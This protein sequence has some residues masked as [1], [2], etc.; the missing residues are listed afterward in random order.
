[1][2][3]PAGFEVTKTDEEWKAELSRERYAVLR[4]AGTEPPWSGDL[5]HVDGA[6]QDGIALPGE[7]CLP[8]LVGLGDFERGLVP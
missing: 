4:R 1:M 8:F 6:A 7:L 3:E 2:T 5:L